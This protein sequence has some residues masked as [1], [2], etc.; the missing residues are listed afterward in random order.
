MNASRFLQK[1]VVATM[2]LILMAGSALP[3]VATDDMRYLGKP[4]TYWLQ[5]L[6]DRNEEM[7][8]LAF[9]AIR[10]LGPEARQAVPELTAIVAAPFNPIRIGK[11]SPKAIARKLYDIEVRAEAI[12][13]LAAIGESASAATAPLIRWALTTRVIPEAVRNTD[14][15]ELFIELIM[16]DTEQR[17][18]IASAIGSLGPDASEAIASLVASP[19]PMK[20]KFGVAILN[21]GAPPIA[22]KLLRSRKC[23]DRALGL[24]ILKD[25]D[26]VVARPHLDW[27]QNRIVCEA[28]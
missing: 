14:D 8:S 17:M 28:N 16:M 20:R 6:R 25:M 13:A 10:G 11:D 26:L 15:E 3:V 22:S 5:V 19:D 12:D 9:D 23:D 1:I 18:R 4:L 7:M 2:M 21:E 24:A 27:L